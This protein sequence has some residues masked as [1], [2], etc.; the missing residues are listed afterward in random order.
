M[1]LTSKIPW[2]L[3]FDVLLYQVA[4]KQPQNALFHFFH[5]KAYVTKFDLAIK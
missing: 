1:T 2:G 3:N 5:S 4:Q